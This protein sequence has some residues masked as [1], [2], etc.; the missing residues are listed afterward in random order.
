MRTHV[1]FISDAFPSYLNEDEEINPGIWGKKL[2][3]F[4]V[5]QL[6]QHGITT[7][8]FYAEDWGWEIPI[9]NKE[10]P[11]FVGCGNQLEPEGNHFLCFVNPSKP[12]VKT[13]LFKSVDGTADINRVAEAL[14]SILTGNPDI[15]ELRWWDENEI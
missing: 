14:D 4:L 6:S 15:K 3:E 2:A 10:F 7:E 5:T 12:K 13:G 11:M 9:V 8:E 1:E